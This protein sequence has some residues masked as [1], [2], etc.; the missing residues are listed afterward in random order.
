MGR[1]ETDDGADAG[2]H[3]HLGP[4]VTSTRRA[5][6]TIDIHVLPHIDLVLLS[7]YHEDH[8]DKKVEA[9]LR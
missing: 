6:P 7:H 5:K 8:L 2:D 1:Y 9:S 4:G 3:V